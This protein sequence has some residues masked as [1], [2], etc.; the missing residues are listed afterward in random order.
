[1]SLRIDN[2]PT[3]GRSRLHL[4]Q[5]SVRNCFGLRQGYR[6]GEPNLIPLAVDH[7][8]ERESRRQFRPET[9]V[10]VLGG[11]RGRGCRTRVLSQ[12]MDVLM[13]QMGDT[14]GA[15]RVARTVSVGLGAHRRSGPPKQER[16]AA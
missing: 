1:L 4:C 9:Q 2:V 10:P 6:D 13:Q 8:A 16:R 3:I 12:R 5:G 14:K 11:G 7:V 15:R